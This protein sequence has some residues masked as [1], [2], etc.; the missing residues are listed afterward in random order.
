MAQDHR[1]SHG[2]RGWTKKAPRQTPGSLRQGYQ[3]TTLPSQR[4][5]HLAPPESQEGWGDTRRHHAE[6]QQFK[7]TQRGDSSALSHDRQAHCGS[8]TLAM[9]IGRD[10]N[11]AVTTTYRKRVQLKL[12]NNYNVHPWDGLP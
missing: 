11:L 7:G 5:L 4:G 1:G 9:A 6:G 10:Q 2:S 3:E 8:G 12:N